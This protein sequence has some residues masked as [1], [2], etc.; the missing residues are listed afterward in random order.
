M[1]TTADARSNIP[2]WA[3]DRMQDLHAQLSSQQ[4]AGQIR[5]RLLTNDERASVPDK[6]QTLVDMPQ[7]WGRLRDMT[8]ES[9]VLD[10]AMRM[11]LVSPGDHQNLHEALG[12]VATPA[13]GTGP[14]PVWDDTAHVLRFQ[15]RIIRRLHRPSRSVNMI[16]IL[17]AFEE[18]GWP[19]KIDDPLPNGRDPGRL[20]ET[21]RSLNRNLEHIRFHADGSGEGVRWELA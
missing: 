21:V 2:A 9:A 4:I 10:L 11:N 8:L 12:L 17:T 3:V 1:S 13:G 16:A 5:A 7:I 18:E 6:P 15:G 14:V 20:R 19:R